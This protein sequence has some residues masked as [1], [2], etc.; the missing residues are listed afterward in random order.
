MSLSDWLRRRRHQRA[1]RTLARW[2]PQT[3]GHFYSPLTDPEALAAEAP[4]L[5]PPTA[6]APGIDFDDDGHR[7]LLRDVFP[8]LLADFDY[9]RPATGDPQR[10]H[11]DN[12]QFGDAD[13]RTLFALLRHWRPARMVEVGSGFST[14]LA[15]DVNRRWLG[16]AMRLTAIEP[17]P[18]DFLHGLDGLQALRVERVQDTP[19]AVF[20]ELDAGDVLFVDSSHVLKTG[21]DLVHLL[22]RVLPVLRAGVRVHVHDVF[23]PDD[24][25]PTWVVDQN[26]GWNEQ[27]ALQ[28]MLAA[29]PRWRVV[30][31][32]HYALTRLADDARAAFGDLAGQPWQAGSVW[33]ERR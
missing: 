7:R 22:T 26:R 3:P 14:L 23:L 31:A 19:M 12:G 1:L 27:Y 21:S 20:A 24:Y 6:E 30:F 15:A 18:R 32:A 29:N 10:F 9:P 17:Y 11:L 13:A 2:L 16:G 5:W 33:I 28:A 25:P 4:R 8:P